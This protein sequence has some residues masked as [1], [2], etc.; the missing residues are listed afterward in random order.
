[1][2]SNI[3]LDLR[4]SSTV[5]FSVVTY[6]CALMRDTLIHALCSGH[7]LDGYGYDATVK[8]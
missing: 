4:M 1:M 2:N 7:A 3:T 8:R 6:C 5:L